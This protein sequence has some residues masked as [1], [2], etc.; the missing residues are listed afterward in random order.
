MEDKSI[1]NIE[2]KGLSYHY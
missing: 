1:V 2:T